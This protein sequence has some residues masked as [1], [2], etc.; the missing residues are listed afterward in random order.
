MPSPKFPS[1]RDRSTSHSSRTE[2]VLISA[3]DKMQQ[4]VAYTHVRYTLCVYVWMYCIYIC[5][6]TPRAYQVHCGVTFPIHASCQNIH[7]TLCMHILHHIY[8]LLYIIPVLLLNHKRIGYAKGMD[9]EASLTVDMWKSV[10]RGSPPHSTALYENAYTVSSMVRKRSQLLR[11]TVFCTFTT[12]KGV[13]EKTNRC[14]L[15]LIPKRNTTLHSKHSA[16]HVDTERETPP[17]KWSLQSVCSQTRILEIN[18]HSSFYG[19]SPD[20]HV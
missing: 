4:M 14:S 15:R 12:W 9:T 5:I 6:H 8:T 16:Q 2:S 7:K 11:M 13:G 1:K 10:C 17:Q 18:N 3:L 19:A 20:P